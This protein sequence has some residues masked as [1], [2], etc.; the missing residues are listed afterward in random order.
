M[1]ETRP[2]TRDTG[3]A[4]P[5]HSGCTSPTEGVQCCALSSHPQVPLLELWT[6]HCALSETL[7]SPP[8]GTQATGEKVMSRDSPFLAVRSINWLKER[9]LLKLE[10]GGSNPAASDSYGDRASARARREALE[11]RLATLTSRVEEDGHR[12]Y[13]KLYEGA[14]TE[15][16]K[17]KAKLQEAQLELADVRCKLEKVA[18]WELCDVQNGRTAGVDSSP[19][20]QQ[21]GASQGTY[22]WAL[23]VGIGVILPRKAQEAGPCRRLVLTE[24]K[25]DNQRLKDENGALIRVISKLSK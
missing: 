2:L 9:Q 10:S 17:L 6:R 25:S 21:P 13:R 4:P 23:V 11:A 20:L 22:T 24:L 7:S 8:V 19:Q 14:L 5:P 15:N 1:E 16:Q 18:Q 12:D 3:P